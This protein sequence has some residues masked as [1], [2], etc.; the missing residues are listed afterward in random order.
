[1]RNEKTDTL[2][3]PAYISKIAWEISK[4]GQIFRDYD[5]SQNIRDVYGHLELVAR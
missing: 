2:D 1:M 4:F 5:L 3:T